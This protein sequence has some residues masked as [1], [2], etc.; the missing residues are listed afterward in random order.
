MID[1]SDSIILL[2]FLSEFLNCSEKRRNCHAHHEVENSIAG[3]NSSSANFLTIV[4]A[5]FLKL[6]EIF[7][8]NKLVTYSHLRL[9]I[10]CLRDDKIKKKMM[11]KNMWDNHENNRLK[12]IDN[13]ARKF[14]KKRNQ[15]KS[16]ISPL[17]TD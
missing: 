11:K 12:Q 10:C 1:T 5:F 7:M 6:T 9:P 8:S 15:M 4:R 16:A 3:A 14:H 2:N 17:N 13:I